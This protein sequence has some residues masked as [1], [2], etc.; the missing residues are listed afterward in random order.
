MPDIYV[1]PYRKTTIIKK[2][3]ILLKEIAEVSAPANIK[4]QVEAL[5]IKKITDDT[6]THYLITIIEIIDVITSHIPNATVSNVGE[7]DVIVQ[8]LPEPIKKRPVWEWIKVLG[9]CL[10]IFAGATVAI[11]AYQTDVSLS[12]TF[13][14]LNKVFTGQ[15]D[16]NPLWITIPYSIGMPV[17]VL[18]FFNHIGNKK[19][20]DDPTPVEVEI[21][22]FK[23]DV[24]TTMIE[25]ITEQKRGQLE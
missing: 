7:M 3:N 8:Y 1:R 23:T 13:T 25:S 4:S 19:F 6:K 2:K 15:I 24:D 9:V 14:V 5:C 10:I 21:N 18:V 11:M 17:G 22:T 16:S 20:T 12:K